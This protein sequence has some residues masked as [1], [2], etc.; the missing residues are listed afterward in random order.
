MWKFLPVK[1]IAMEGAKCV[2]ISM[3]GGGGEISKNLDFMNMN[4]FEKQSTYT[5]SKRHACRLEYELRFKY[6]HIDMSA[7]YVL[8]CGSRNPDRFP[9][10][11][12]KEKEMKA[13]LI[14]CR[15]LSH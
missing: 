14:S 15:I 1:P 13:K 10:R 6:T 5:I 11:K 2:T 9:W 8:V 7:T 12:V 4:N 3:W